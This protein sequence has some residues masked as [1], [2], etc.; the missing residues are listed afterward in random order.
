MDGFKKTRSHEKDILVPDCSVVSKTA[1]RIAIVSLFPERLTDLIQYLSQNCVD[2]FITHTVK[3][4]VMRAMEPDV[5]I[6]DHTVAVPISCK[7]NADA[8]GNLT[9]AYL[10]PRQADPNHLD[11][12]ANAEVIM[13]PT[14]FPEVLYRLRVLER[15]QRKPFQ[16]L[17]NVQVYSGLVIDYNRKRAELNGTSLGLTK[18]EFDILW[19]LIQSNGRVL[20]RDEIMSTVWGEKYFPGSNTIDVHIKGLRRKLKDSIRNPKYIQTVRGIGYRFASGT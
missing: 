9:A 17:D 5:M 2:I 20:S 8:V 12:S 18:S 13:Y 16:H 14:D 7:S 11:L 4:A 10:L 6:L 15:R 3:L 19:I 1:L